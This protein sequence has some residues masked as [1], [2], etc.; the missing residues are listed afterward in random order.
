MNECTVTLQPQQTSSA[1][2]SPYAVL[3]EHTVAVQLSRRESLRIV[4]DGSFGA[5]EYLINAINVEVKSA[6]AVTYLLQRAA[7]PQRRRTVSKQHLRDGAE[8]WRLAAGAIKE[9]RSS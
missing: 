4:L 2:T 3:L 1:A 8:G 5:A 6:V 9:K 7:A